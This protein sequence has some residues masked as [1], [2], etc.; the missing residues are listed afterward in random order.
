MTCCG[1]L[2]QG[3]RLAVLGLEH[4]DLVAGHVVG[5]GT[6]RQRLERRQH[7]RQL[8]VRVGDLPQA[9][10]DGDDDGDHQQG[11]GRDHEP[12]AGQP[13]QRAHNGSTLSA[14]P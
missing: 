11:T 10:P 4:R 6:L 7:D 3:D 1:N 13:R 14:T 5:V 2:R 12:E 8:L 9:W